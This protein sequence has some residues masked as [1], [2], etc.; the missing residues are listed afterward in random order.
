MWYLS[1]CLPRDAAL[2][3]GSEAETLLN[4]SVQRAIFISYIYSNYHGQ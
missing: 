4:E 3:I 2:Q 1:S